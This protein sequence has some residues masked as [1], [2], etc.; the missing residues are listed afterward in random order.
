MMGIQ[1]YMLVQFDN[2]K[3]IAESIDQEIQYFCEWYSCKVKEIVLNPIHTGFTYPD[4]VVEF[5]TVVSPNCMYIGK[6][7][8]DE[9]AVDE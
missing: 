7:D 8:K 5:D 2:T 6:E 1:V 9:Q 4:V 3:N